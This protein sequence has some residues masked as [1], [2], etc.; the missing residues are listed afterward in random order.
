MKRIDAGLEYLK[1]LG[2]KPTNSFNKAIANYGTIAGKENQKALEDLIFSRYGHSDN[3]VEWHRKL[4]NIKNINFKS[5]I[6]FTGDSDGD[7]LRTVCNWIRDNKN[8]F[9]KRILEVGCDCG[10]LT[11]FL[12]KEFPDSQIV[13]IDHFPEGLEIGRQIAT[14]LGLQNIEFQCEDVVDCEKKYD[15]VFS[16]R[17]MHENHET[18]Q[19]EDS[20]YLFF[21]PLSRVCCLTLI[22]Y[23]KA[24]VDRLDNN[25]VLVSI[26]RCSL[27]PVFIG[28]MN[29][30]N[31][32]G[33]VLNLDYYTEMICKEYKNDKYF[34]VIVGNKTGKIYSFEDVYEQF[35]KII[36]DKRFGSSK[37]M[38]YD[39]EAAI[40][41]DYNIK[42]ILVGY[43][44]YEK[45]TNRNLGRVMLCTING[46]D[47]TLLVYQQVGLD[48]SLEI[49]DIKEKDNKI[50]MI[51]KEIEA[52]KNKETRVEEITCNRAADGIV[53]ITKK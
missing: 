16:S 44:V 47:E 20:R 43:D 37:Y 51:N 2:I 18:K 13:A 9:G 11:C 49:C 32:S 33:I 52:S 26:E 19:I 1:L 29:A 35:Y 8:L 46:S 22:D 17:T 53:Y 48:M 6:S 40:F 15:T 14:N 42:D 21:R 25:G 30:L 36:A 5:G 12:A 7:Y 45:Y 10:I 27:D 23:A 41:A 31:N 34:S 3:G 39:W 50:Q 4:Y 38:L 24:L 28:W